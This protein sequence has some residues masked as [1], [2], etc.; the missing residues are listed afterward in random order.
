MDAD[1]QTI[2]P[3]GLWVIALAAVLLLGLAARVGLACAG[4]L[5][6]APE[7][8]SDAKEYD[9]YAWNL[10]QG[11]G[12]R[13]MS[14]DVTDQNHLT[15]YRPPGPSVLMAGVYLVAGH[16]YA[17]VRLVNCLLGVCSIFLVY[18]LGRRTFSELVG[19]LAAAMYALV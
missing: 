1:N 19:I 10:A 4:G 3:H 18:R 9:A 8:S 7:P 14:P 15:A 2:K 12:Y 16:N 17:A 13:G 5:F 6:S 11:N